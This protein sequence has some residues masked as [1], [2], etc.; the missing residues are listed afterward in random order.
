MESK[1]CLTF[2]QKSIEALIEYTKNLAEGVLLFIVF[3]IVAVVVK[4]LINKAG[5][6]VSKEKKVIFNLLANT[7][8]TVL[9][10]IGLIS[11]LGT[12]EVDVSALVAG[13]GLTGFAIGY[14]LKDS[15][16][17]LMSGMLVLFYQPFKVGQSIEVDGLSG[18]VKNI[19][20]RY[21]TLV[22]EGKTILIP[23]TL[24]FTKTVTIF[25]S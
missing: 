11:A 23:N 12:M 2:Y 17:N 20:L 6:K 4:K 24:V 9:L 16:S 25:Q 19:D 13:L 22:T 14:A 8:K 5:T 1:F 3:L 10:V 15:L 7:S 18:K 21:T